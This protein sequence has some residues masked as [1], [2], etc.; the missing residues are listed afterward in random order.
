MEH[1]GQLVHTGWTLLHCALNPD[2]P[3]SNIQSDAGVF[4]S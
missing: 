1:R 2:G 4:Y 3:L